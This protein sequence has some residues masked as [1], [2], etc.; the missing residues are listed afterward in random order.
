MPDVLPDEFDLAGLIPLV[1]LPGH[2][3]KRPSGKPVALSAV[4]RWASA[5]VGGRV[6]RTAEVG[7]IRYTSIEWVRE[8]I[9]AGPS[10]HVDRGRES[11]APSRRQRD[12]RRAERALAEAGI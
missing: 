12:L 2:L 6:L 3:P 9:G 1:K 8:F 11:R 4:Y 7:G 10:S 5:G